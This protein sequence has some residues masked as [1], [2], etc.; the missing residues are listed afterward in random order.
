[1]DVMLAFMIFYCLLN[2]I[3]VLKSCQ[4]DEVAQH[5]VRFLTSLPERLSPALI[6][7]GE[8]DKLR[9]HLLTQCLNSLK[10]IAE[11][12]S[13]AVDT[14]ALEKR[15]RALRRLLVFL[16]SILD[17]SEPDNIGCFHP[18]GD[19]SS[20]KSVTFVV[21]FNVK[22]I[23]RKRSEISLVTTS[24][25]DH[26]IS[27]I[28]ES[29]ERKPSDI[30]VFR[31]GKDITLAETRSKT[32]AQLG[33]D[34]SVVESVAAADR[35]TSDSKPAAVTA[36]SN[37]T[38]AVE[39]E[40][41]SN[42]AAVGRKDSEL[43]HL[44]S[45]NEDKSSKLPAVM[46]SH[47]QDYFSLLMK[48]CETSSSLDICEDLWVVINRLPTSPNVLKQWKSLVPNEQSTNEADEGRMDVPDDN[49]NNRSVE[50]LLDGL[51]GS[52]PRLLYR[53]QI[54]EIL[55][56][57]EDATYASMNSAGISIDFSQQWIDSFLRQNGISAVCNA[58]KWLQKR[59]EV[60]V[61]S[62]G[63]KTSTVISPVML[64]RALELISKLMR[65]LLVRPFV[66]WS[67]YSLTSSDASERVN[68][69]I[70]FISN[71]SQNRGSAA[72]VSL[73]NAVHSSA[74]NVNDSH[75]PNHSSHSHN[76]TISK[77]L[78]D[79]LAKEWGRLLFSSTRASD[80][81]YCSL[82]FEND[83]LETLQYHTLYVMKLIR[84]LSML[85][86]WT[87][88]A[89]APPSIFRQ[90]GSYEQCT[91]FVL[92][93]LE[94]L[95][96]VWGS[97]V[98]MK[99]T[100][101]QKI[102]LEIRNAWQPESAG[103]SACGQLI[104]QEHAAERDISSTNPNMSAM[105]LLQGML[106]DPNG[107]SSAPRLSDSRAHDFLKLIGSDAKADVGNKDDDEYSFENPRESMA[108]KI[109][110]WFCASVLSILKLS[111]E[112]CYR[113][114]V[115]VTSTETKLSSEHSP[116]LFRQNQEL[117][118]Y[119]FRK[120]CLLT[121]LQLRP[122]LFPM[123]SS[124][125]ETNSV[126]K[127]EPLFGLITDA[128]NDRKFESILS[129]EIKHAVGSDILAEILHA[130]L[131]LRNELVNYDGQQ[132]ASQ[133]QDDTFASDNFKLLA[134]EFC[135]RDYWTKL[136]SDSS[137]AVLLGS[138]SVFYALCHWDIEVIEALRDKSA[139]TILLHNCLGLWGEFVPA[140]C[141]DQSSRLAINISILPVFYG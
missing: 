88:T 111:T 125:G 3:Q 19:R 45:E 42:A 54:I 90:I 71:T 59:L 86:L 69:F 133:C 39:S 95:F 37:I 118:M 122:R 47:S 9:N 31:H 32:L 91:T 139:V 43:G 62:F 94:D 41:C 110:K 98:S 113:L 137:Q 25:V 49:D 61:S 8:L 85:P 112:N 76:I 102:Y 12:A 63:S 120:V 117:A 103:I 73:Q 134:N 58:F 18:H 70:T 72:S 87:S 105:S 107:P 13:E 40:P 26:L 96:V 2:S 89:L 101:L 65:A 81:S 135:V 121:L 128:L 16:S 30:K 140:F 109:S 104:A 115:I 75:Y 99:P 10:M 97:M 44:T 82:L 124:Y 23:K 78:H 56:Q 4:S 141:R 52:L 66:L 53:L 132:C 64:L 93:I 131:A 136:S 77:L 36:M 15:D 33:I 100:I 79:L 68:M 22:N 83:F 106:L 67:K 35:Y 74:M 34:G 17:E 130:S 55:V 50:L 48:L 80:I 7:K 20:G 129:F 11:E 108:C 28:A 38:A 116:S 46:L 5:A 84:Q 29:M 126:Q 24:K 51:G 123:S 6:I 60:Y 119:S 114:N 21:N 57:P 92:K 27:L 127:V 14:S 1:M 138:L